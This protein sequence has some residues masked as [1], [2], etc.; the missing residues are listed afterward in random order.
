MAAI[1]CQHCGAS[2]EVEDGSAVR[3]GH[4]ASSD[5]SREW[6]LFERGAEIHRCTGS[7]SSAASI[8][9]G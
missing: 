1:E 8:G 6:I 2:V 5:K 4:S 9:E 3:N 7:P